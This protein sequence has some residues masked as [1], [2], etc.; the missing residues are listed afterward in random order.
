MLTKVKIVHQLACQ[1]C[2]KNYCMLGLVD[3]TIHIGDDI[4]CESNEL[5]LNR[6]H[7]P[8]GVS[9]YICA[10]FSGQELLERWCGKG[11]TDE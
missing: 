5:F 11:S 6:L 8:V 3:M 9:K 10:A 1:M 2:L 4:K 7:R